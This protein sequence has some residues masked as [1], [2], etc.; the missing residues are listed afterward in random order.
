MLTTQQRIELQQ[1]FKAKSQWITDCG[2]WIWT[3]YCTFQGYGLLSFQ[4]VLQKAHRFSISL[5]K[6]KFLTTA[7]FHT[8]AMRLPALIQII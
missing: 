3:A 4:A 8:Y 5:S 1:K 2:C 6:A 7:K